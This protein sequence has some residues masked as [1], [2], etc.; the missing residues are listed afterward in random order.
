MAVSCSMRIEVD[1]GTETAAFDW[2]TFD[3]F[4]FDTDMTPVGADVLGASGVRLKSGIDGNGP[5]DVVASTGELQYVLRN[6]AGNSG[7]LQGYYSPGHANVHTG[8]AYGLTMRCSFQYLGVD[9]VKFTG[10]IRVIAP[11]AGRYGSRR[12]TVTAY[13]IMRDLAESD[14]RQV[15]IQSNKTETELLSALVAVVAFPFTTSFNTGV[16]SFPYAFDNVAGNTKVLAV[17]R[18]V[19]VSS[20]GMLFANGDG[21]LCYRSRH[22]LATSESQATFS[23]AMTDLSVP[24]SLDG[25]YNRVRVTNHPKTISAAATEELYTIP[26]GNAVEISSGATVYVWTDYTDPNDR[27]T[28]IG[29]TAVVTA[30]VG[31]THYAAFA[32][33]DGTGANMTASITAAIDPFGTTAKWTLT[34][35]AST[36]AYIT[37]QKVIGKAVRDPG[38]QTYESYTAKS[39]GDRPIDIDLPYQDDPYI[40]QSAADYLVSQYAALSQQV[41]SMTFIA[42]ASHANML[43]AMQIG[44]GDRVTVTETVTGLSSVQCLV[45]SIEFEIQQGIYIVCRWGL[46]PANTIRFWQWGVVGASEWGSTTVYGF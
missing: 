19:V 39:Y 27:Q 25:V 7:A 45:Q 16:D 35:T 22:T 5:I 40:G 12:V 28:K 36:T 17:M 9:Y 24:T 1:F 33:A 38:P 26:T 6:D 37:L 3:S 46:R 4:A 21:T 29:G 34:N 14:A 8:W 10:K 31:G 42:N 44:I 41:E 43:A 20:L 32:N 15:T 18:D 2:K 13:D 23:D 11:D 30:L